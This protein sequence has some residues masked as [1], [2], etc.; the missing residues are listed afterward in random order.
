M[1]VTWHKSSYSSSNGGECLEVGAGVPGVIPVRD[2]KTPNGPVLVFTP[3]DWSAFVN[4]VTSG[5]M[6]R[7]ADCT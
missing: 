1:P 7:S 2:S 4:G 3:A 5:P 6:K